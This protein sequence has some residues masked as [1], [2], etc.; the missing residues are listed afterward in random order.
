MYEFVNCSL[1][2]EEQCAT[3]FLVI[4]ILKLTDPQDGVKFMDDA[5]SDGEFDLRVQ[6]LLL[7]FMCSTD[8]K[9][10]SFTHID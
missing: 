2:A 6:Y 7:L 5:C 10:H 4:T 1:K 8:H 9:G 3:D